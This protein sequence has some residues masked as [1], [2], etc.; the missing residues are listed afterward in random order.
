MTFW[1]AKSKEETPEYG[2]VD[3]TGG[4]S[5][6]KIKGN[7]EKSRWSNDSKAIYYVNESSGQLFQMPIG[8]EAKQITDF[9]PLSIAAFDFS[10]DEKN[11]IF[12]L[13]ETTGELALIKNFSEQS[14]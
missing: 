10:P 9:Y 14:K 12:S 7:I 4:N 11:I 2:I 1:G 5:F 8:G 6:L 13:G 3:R